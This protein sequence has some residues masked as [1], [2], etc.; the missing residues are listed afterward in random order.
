VIIRYYIDSN[1]NEENTCNLNDFA[2]KY[3]KDNEQIIH[4][5]KDLYKAI[6]P[7]IGTGINTG[8]YAN[9]FRKTDVIKNP[10]V[11]CFDLM[12]LSSRPR[13]ASVLIPTLLDMIMRNVGGKEFAHRRKMI[14]VDEAWKFLKDPSVGGFI[15]EMYSTIRKLNGSITILTQNL[16]TIMESPIAGSILINTS[17]YY[18]MGSNHAH[19]PD[20]TP[21]KTPLLR[22]EA[23]G[24][25]DKALTG[26]DIKQILSQK[27]KRDFYLLTPFFCGQLRF[28]PILDFIMLSTTHPDHKKILEKYKKQIGAD[29]VTPAVMEAARNE[30]QSIVKLFISD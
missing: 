9:Y 5:G 11:V 4:A 29:F 8:I 13:L 1:N 2:E 16:Q 21:P 26:Y 20:D 15:Q 17:Y 22:I 19:D 7:F 30:F 23:K 24:A 28:F 18:L 10:N 14:V 27:P 12:G 6:A 3:L 25:A